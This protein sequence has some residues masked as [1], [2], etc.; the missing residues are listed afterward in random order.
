MEE[1]WRQSYIP[2]W[3]VSSLGNVRNK[4]L[5]RIIKPFWKN[6]YLSVGQ[7]GRDSIGRHKVHKLICIAFH[8]E[9]PGDNYCIDHIDGNKENNRPDNLRWCEWRENSK[10]GNKPLLADS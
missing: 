5:H 10:K 3:E 6:R 2:L 1:E 7:G 9:R 4:K 8:G